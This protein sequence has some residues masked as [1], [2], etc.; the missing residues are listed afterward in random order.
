MT[1]LEATPGDIAAADRPDRI[2]KER[3]GIAG[4][5]AQGVIA[6]TRHGTVANDARSEARGKRASMPPQLSGDQGRAVPRE[7]L[8]HN[9]AHDRYSCPQGQPLPRRGI[10]CT[11]TATRSIIH[12][13]APE[14]CSCCP[15][16]ASCCGAARA[17]T[18]SRPDGGGLP[19]RVRASLATPHAKRGLRQRLYGAEP[20]IA[21]LKARH[22]PRR[23]QG[24]G[25]AAVLSQASG[26]ATAYHIKK[27][28]RRHCHRP[29]A[30]ACARRSWRP[31]LPRPRPIPGWPR[32]PG[33]G[34][35]AA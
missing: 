5:G 11:G 20:P 15:R 17:R 27:L 14:A 33:N 24:R 8:V 3:E 35:Y 32:S 31:A 34:R 1:A 12:R 18:I 21:E 22:G 30:V 19:A 10:S 29:Q 23:A 25:H 6:D 16:R 26:A 9:A 4:R 28:V 2:C 7:E 13:A